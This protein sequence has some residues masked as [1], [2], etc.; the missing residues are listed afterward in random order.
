MAPQEISTEFPSTKQRVSVLDSSMAYID[1]GAPT[2]TS[3]TVVFV[4]GNPTSSYIW[5][6]IIPHLSPIARCI[7]PDLVG[8]GDSGKMPSNT[9]RV[10]DH[11]RYF[12]AFME[13]VIGGSRD[14][15][16]FLVVQDWGSAL[17]LNWASHNEERVA[18][19]TFMEFLLAGRKLEDLRGAATIFRDFRTGDVGR[20]LIIDENVFVETILAKVGVARGLTEAEMSHYRAPFL[21][22]A[23]REPIYRFPNEIPFDGHPADVAELVEAYFV[24]LK[25]TS[26]PKLMFWGDPGAIVSVE[27]AEELAG[28]MKNVKSVGISPGRHYLQEDDPHLIGRVTKEFVEQVWTAKKK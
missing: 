4:H 10:R 13:T 6:N 11:I 2:L 18:G 27:M 9:Y 7:A 16:I 20:R 3:P 26:V 22:P 28:Q 8:F 25:T 14:Q 12:D 23:D 1:T 19:L 15:N 24:W 5:R 21:D 17:G